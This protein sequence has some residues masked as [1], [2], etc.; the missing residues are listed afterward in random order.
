MTELEI[1][2]YVDDRTSLVKRLNEIAIYKGHVTREDFYYRREGVKTYPLRIRKETQNGICKILLT[3]KRKKI[4]KGKDNI[5]IEVNDERECVLSSSD[6]LEAFFEDNKVDLYLKKE[7][8]VDDWEYKGHIEVL[9]D[10]K[11]TLELC[12]IPNLGDFLEIEILSNENNENILQNVH[13]E[14][15]RLLEMSGISKSRIENR[16]YAQLLK[17]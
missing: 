12:T 2:A 7:K 11:A 14:L 17:G 4:R 15:E 10:Y 13:K 6:V 8:I 1:K 16:S 3:Y 9:G 5:D